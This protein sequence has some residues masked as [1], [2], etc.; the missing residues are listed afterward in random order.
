MN[1]VECK[2]YFDTDIGMT[3]CAA[4]K[5]EHCYC[6]FWKSPKEQNGRPC[7]HYRMDI[8]GACDNSSAYFVAWKAACKLEKGT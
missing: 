7:M 4:E 8:K 5:G 6:T 1:N 2:S 3:I